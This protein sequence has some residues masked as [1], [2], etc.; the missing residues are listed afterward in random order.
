MLNCHDVVLGLVGVD[1][2]VR[3]VVVVVVVLDVSV[4]DGLI[5]I[6]AACL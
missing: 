3:S 2:V 6:R 1:A 5:V 4:P